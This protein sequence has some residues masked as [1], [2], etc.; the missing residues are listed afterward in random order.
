MEE[1]GGIL[2]PRDVSVVTPHQVTDYGV[3]SYHRQMLERV[4][5][6]MESVPQEERHV[7]GLTV[8]IP[9]GLV[10]TLKAELDAL[11]ER[12][13]HL[14]DDQAQGAERVYQVNLNLIPLS[15]GC[16]R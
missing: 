9:E 5:D 1:E 13:L 12:L 8:A 14:C 16:A 11:Q 6:A 7:L 15:R 2:R 4:H 10:P 3:R